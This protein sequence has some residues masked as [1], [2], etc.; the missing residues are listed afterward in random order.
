MATAN[1]IAAA[2]RD[3]ALIRVRVNHTLWADLCSRSVFPDLGLTPD[4]ELSGG[5]W[6][7]WRPRAYAVRL[8]S[9]ARLQSPL[10][11]G[12]RISMYRSLSE[13]IE[14]E[15]EEAAVRTAWLC[16]DKPRALSARQNVQRFVATRGQLT[17]LGAPTDLVLP[18]SVGG[19]VR[20]STYRDAQNRLCV[21]LRA[22]SVWPDS[23]FVEVKANE[24]RKNAGPKVDKAIERLRNAPA[25]PAAYRQQQAKN[26]DAIARVLMNIMDRDCGYEYAPSAIR[27]IQANMLRLRSILTNGEVIGAGP[28]PLLAAKVAEVAKTDKPLQSFLRLVSSSSEAR[29]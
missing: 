10:A 3:P 26:A 19:P 27:E 5:Y 16:S 22:D 28:E 13:R 8:L 20:K 15:I 2:S 14:K 24:E 9:D 1:L 25:S 11:K 29:K 21:V 7:H 6:I 18:G 23:F 12:A 4:A 17:K